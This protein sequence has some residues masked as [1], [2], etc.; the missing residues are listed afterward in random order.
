[1][2]V[3]QAFETTTGYSAQEVIGQT[4]RILKSERHNEEFYVDLWDIILQ[5]RTFQGTIINKRKNGQTYYSDQTITPIQNSSG[6]I[7]HFITIGK[8]ITKR[9]ENRDKVDRLNKNLRIEKQKIEE[10][11][12][13]GEKI[14]TITNFNRL[15]D[16][17]Y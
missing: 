17:Y 16:F 5:G 4:P 8:D 6:T 13:F 1:M 15:V 11:L 9:I 3:N 10:I 7:T 14:E 12:N 2:Y